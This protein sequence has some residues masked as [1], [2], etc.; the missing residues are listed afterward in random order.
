MILVKSLAHAHIGQLYLHI[1]YPI[2]QSIRLVLKSQPICY[3]YAQAPPSVRS[4]TAGIS[5]HI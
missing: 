4:I 3:K 2:H 1:I 5:N